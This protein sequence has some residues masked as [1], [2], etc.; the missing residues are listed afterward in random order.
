MDRGIIFFFKQKTAY[1]IYQCD[2]SSDVCSSDLNALEKGAPTS[3]APASMTQKQVSM[4][5][6]RIFIRLVDMIEFS[7]V[8]RWLSMG[9]PRSRLVK[10]AKHMGVEPM[11]GRK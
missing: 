11:P 3:W 9:W 5:R 2:W 7:L 1:E 10:I 4:D 6:D 8:I